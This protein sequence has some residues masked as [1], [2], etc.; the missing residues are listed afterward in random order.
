MIHFH[1]P[2]RQRHGR[3]QVFGFKAVLV[4]GASVVALAATATPDRALAQDQACQDSAGNV[5]LPLP[6]TNQ[7]TEAGLTNTTCNVGA[8]A[9]GAFNNASGP[10]S[11]AF[12]RSNFALGSSSSA[13]GYFNIASA[14]NSSAFGNSS[15]ARGERASAFGYQNFARAN[16]SSAV[17]VSN[18]A[19]G[20]RSIAVGYLNAATG[21][22]SVALGAENNHSEFGVITSG[23][24]SSAVGFRNLAFGDASSAFGYQSMAQGDFSSAFGFRSSTTLDAVGGLAIGGWADSNNDGVIDPDE[25]TFVS[26]KSAIAVGNATRAMGEFSAAFG[27]G[28]IV[29]TAAARGTAIGIN[30]RVTA[31]EGTAIGWG[32]VADRQGAVS[33]GAANAEHNI[34]HVANA[35]E[36]TD[37][38]NL[39]QMLAADNFLGNGL[40][41]I[42]GGGMSYLATASV[43]TI[44]FPQY[45]IQG[46]T[47]TSVASALTAIDQRLTT[48]GGAAGIPGPA[49]PAGPVGPQ[50]PQGPGNPLSVG[51]DDASKGVLTLEGANGTRVANVAD[52]VA[53]TDAANVRQVQAGDAQTLAAAHSYADAGDAVVK[54]YADTRDVAT[55]NSARTYADAGDTRTLQ[56]AMAYTDQKLSVVDNQLAAI[57]QRLDG[58]ESRIDRMGAMSSA[59]LN[60]AMNVAGSLAG[61][62]RLGVGIGFQNGEEALS[63]GYGRRLG[64]GVSISVG[65][66]FGRHGEQ[67]GGVGIGFDIF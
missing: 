38:V 60:M 2:K 37:A 67:S 22:R 13:F 28:A 59:Q 12:G 7:G 40:S 4:A 48:L 57:G 52:G 41:Q 24:A 64:N 34:I 43:T 61:R 16:D 66:A 55:L 26:G 45:G 10:V 56:S 3:K 36:G 44:V 9:F 19:R 47:Y 27:V 32:A 18:E 35:I 1:N 29:D 15:E 6:S 21:A 8:T 11:T 63:V 17:G 65:G 62:G 33:V 14:W 30:A 46:A 20:D 58:Q 25:L 5:I 39:R 49:G 53:P 50:G 31:I 42:L 54:T 23:L 51:Y